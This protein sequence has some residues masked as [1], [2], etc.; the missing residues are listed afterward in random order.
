[1]KVLPVGAFGI[2]GVHTH[3]L[4]L[5]G[6]VHLHVCQY[7][8]CCTLSTG[9]RW[10]FL[11]DQFNYFLEQANYFSLSFELCETAALRKVTL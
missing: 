9:F 8:G 7:F 11:K 10:V 5:Q 6:S 4:P 1:M 2:G 3:H